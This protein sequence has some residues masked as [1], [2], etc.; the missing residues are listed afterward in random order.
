MVIILKIKYKDFEV[1]DINEIDYLY[2]NINNILYLELK[3]CYNINYIYSLI[4]NKWLLLDFKIDLFF[5]NDFFK[6]NI[7][8]MFLIGELMK[9]LY[10]NKID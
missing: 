9:I 7:L 2:D 5:N 8:W 3:N 6:E 1:I 4:D 10:D